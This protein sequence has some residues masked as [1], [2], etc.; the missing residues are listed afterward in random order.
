MLTKLLQKEIKVINIGLRSFAENLSECGA[1]VININWAPPAQ[2]NQ[3]ILE[4][5][6]RYYALTEKPASCCNKA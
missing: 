6:N 3:K 5:L 4:L 1:D 2:G